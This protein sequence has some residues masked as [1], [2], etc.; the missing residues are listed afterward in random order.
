MYSAE[1]I[2]IGRKLTKIMSIGLGTSQDVT[3][4]S[5]DTRRKNTDT[6]FFTN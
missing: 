3:D 2:L 5:H 6:G 1:E 4:H